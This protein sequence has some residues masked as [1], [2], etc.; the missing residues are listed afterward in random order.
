MV[1]F[2]LPV[3]SNIPQIFIGG[4][5][6]ARHCPGRCRYTG[7]TI[8]MKLMGFCLLWRGF[9]I[10]RFKVNDWPNPH[11]RLSL[12]F[13]GKGKK[14]RKEEKK[15]KV[16][17]EEWVLLTKIVNAS[18]RKGTGSRFSLL[19]SL[20]IYFPLVRFCHLLVCRVFLDRH[21]TFWLPTLKIGE[22]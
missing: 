15:E 13:W 8:D 1:A 12:F 11:T 6:C 19:Y 22:K 3:D 9:R 5:L 18:S 20:D 7:S 2:L 14:E 4:L 21:W 17:S 10:S 16:I